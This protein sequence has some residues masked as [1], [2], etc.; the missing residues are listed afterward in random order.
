MTVIIVDDEKH[1]RDVLCVLLQK[2]SPKSQVIAACAD[3]QSGIEAIEMHHPDIVLLDIEMP[4][5]SGF[6]MLEACSFKNF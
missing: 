6:D 1:C 5:M 4:G 2:Y 3:A